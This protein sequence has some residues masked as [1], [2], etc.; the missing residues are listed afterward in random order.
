MD[1]SK[2]NA[3]MI[4]VHLTGLITYKIIV[5]YSCSFLS[6]L[7]HFSKKCLKY[8]PS[9]C[10]ALPSMM[11]CLLS[12][13]FMCLNMLGVWGW[14]TSVCSWQ[15]WYKWTE[16]CVLKCVVN[17]SARVTQRGF[18]EPCRE[19]DYQERRN[20]TASLPADDSR[21]HTY[22]CHMGLPSCEQTSEREKKRAF[23]SLV[24]ADGQVD[25]G[26]MLELRPLLSIPS[27]PCWSSRDSPGAQRVRETA[28]CRHAR[29]T[30][31]WACALAAGCCSFTGAA[32]RNGSWVSSPT[33]G[34]RWHGP[35]PTGWI[36]TCSRITPTRPSYK[37]WGVRVTR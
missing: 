1:I 13:V 15:Y 31:S 35:G 12:N 37:M 22:F 20:C 16:G 11:H 36:G 3:M 25:I 10:N 18:T 34:G 9:H 23:V 27:P 24:F 28:S 32:C 2:V 26:A 14:D 7:H 5:W 8:V 21:A 33:G 6:T 29:S 19:K 30:C 17:F 4:L